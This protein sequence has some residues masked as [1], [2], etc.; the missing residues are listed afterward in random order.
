MIDSRWEMLD[1]RVA[2]LEKALVPMR[3]EDADARV[4]K[5]AD[6]IIGEMGNPATT[7]QYEALLRGIRKGINLFYTEPAP[8]QSIGEL[9]AKIVND[10]AAIL[11]QNVA[12]QTSSMQRVI[13]E[14]IDERHKLRQKNSAYKARISHSLEL[15]GDVI[16][17]L[18]DEVSE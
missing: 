12:N 9:S 16:Q 18:T 3:G 2:I 13:D 11:N 5:I 7:A 15:L 17:D 4:L 10:K 1:G 6:M 14:L 8:A